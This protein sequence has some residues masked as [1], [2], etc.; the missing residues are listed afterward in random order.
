MRIQIM[1]DDKRCA[2]F[3]TNASVVV[4][5][6]SIERN[7]PGPFQFVP[8]TGS[9]PAR[10]IIAPSEKKDYSRHAVRL[11]PLN[12]SRTGV[13]NLTRSALQIKSGSVDRI[14]GGTKIDQQLPFEIRFPDCVMRV[15]D[16][17]DTGVFSTRPTPP[18]SSTKEK[19][20][21]P[22]AP[23]A[24]S[25]Q[26]VDLVRWMQTTASV[27][28]RTLSSSD[29]IPAAASALVDIVGMD[30]GR[31]FL[32]R[33]GAWSEAAR[34]PLNEAISAPSRT[35]LDRV[36]TEKR[37]FWMNDD[38]NSSMSSIVLSQLSTVV[39]API[40]DAA[41]EVVGVL[42]GDKRIKLG[43]LLQSIGKP[44]ALLVEML[45]SAIATGMARQEHQRKAV[46]AES[47]FAQFFSRELA[48]E[49]TKDPGLLEGRE[50]EVS[51]LFADVRGFSR[52]SERIGPA[53]TVRWI[54]DMM[55]ELS[56][57]V[58]ATSGVLMDYIGDEL[59]SMWVVP[60]HQPDHAVRAVRRSRHD[61]GDSLA[62]RTM[63]QVHGRTVPDRHR[64][65][66]W[67]GVG[68]QYRISIQV[69]IRSARQHGQPG[70]P[71]SGDD[72]IFEAS[73]LGHRTDA[74]V[75]SE[76]SSSP[77]ASAKPR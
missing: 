5:R 74:A 40:F 21:P 42:Y 15:A 39:A 31:V 47:R 60:T 13:H 23:T 4:G 65:Q 57:D 11:E 30:G 64:Y 61:R 37:T 3:R 62:E 7:E 18:I 2:E 52:I 14:Q 24:A 27:F 6:Q 1:V 16:D 67:P 12:Q 22:A 46:Q 28:Q 59:V 32:C 72:E 56:K 29:F 9:E 58:L 26:V 51:L 20:S 77:G 53:E 19:K 35:V 45:A 48:D 25:G 68:R 55:N 8:P 34:Y 43:S 41:G 10:V 76:T 36:R 54:G 44:E 38:C 75:S 63:A 50:A 17:N 66:Y 49:L 71:C 73:L 33:D 69:Q 70:K